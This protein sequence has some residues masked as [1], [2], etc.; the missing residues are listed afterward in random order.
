MRQTLIKVTLLMASTMW[1]VGCSI[2]KKMSDLQ[3]K[4]SE[5]Q[6]V[7][8]LSRVSASYQ[9]PSHRVAFAAYE[10]MKADLA[11]IEIGDI[12]VS[13]DTHYYAKGTPVPKI[14]ETKIPKDYPGFWYDLADHDN[15]TVPTIVNLRQMDFS[16][17]TLSGRGVQVW[18]N[19]HESGMETMLSIQVG[20]RGNEKVS[21]DFLDK[22]SQRL[23][24]PTYK[25][26]SP[27]ERVAFLAFFGKKT[28]PE[29]EIQKSQAKAKA[30]DLEVQG[31]PALP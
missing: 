10:E 30:K 26:G 2:D 17:K 24:T 25:P 14:D 29:T 28:M 6:P 15:G 22:I 21:K 18:I 12:E 11:T 16:G 5:G 4:V 23:T 1:I 13:K 7:W 9:I 27:E 31:L 8:L 19:M 3:A 20:T